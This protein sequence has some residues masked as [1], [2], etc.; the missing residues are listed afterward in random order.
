MTFPA[1]NAW[2]DNIL[3]GSCRSFTEAYYGL[4]GDGMF[5]TFEEVFLRKNVEKPLIRSLFNPLHWFSNKGRTEHAVKYYQ[6]HIFQ[7]ATYADMKKPGSP[8]IVINTS[9]LAHGVRFSF[10]QEYFDLLCSDLLSFP[11]ARAVTASSAVPVAFN[12]IVVEN[13]SDCVRDNPDWLK[14]IRNR[15]EAE[16]NTELITLVAGLETYTDKEQRKFIH[17][18]DGGITDNIGLRAF[19]DVVELLGGPKAYLERTNQVGPN[20][21]VVIAVD[22]ST[23]PV[24]AIDE[25][26]KQPSI[27]ETMSAMSGAQLHRYN[28]ASIDL[29]ENSLLKW[30]NDLSK[31]GN[32][33]IPYFIEV[34]FEDIKESPVKQFFN[35][36]PTSFFLK[37]EQV[38]KLIEAGR[39]LLRNNPDFQR[40]LAD[41][42][43]S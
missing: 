15:A 10:V 19:Y 3:T 13:Y 1:L 22:A 36:I 9:D 21:W 27:K 2:K 11:I 28:D 39:Q 4:H 12:P 29:L 7:G 34:S 30:T 6:K 26:N 20:K 33:V 37:D 35:K 8:M 32:P 40:L 16:H 41:I 43:N 38:N 5:D 18:V 31:P 25:T 17:V 42:N 23:S 14:Q 24:Y